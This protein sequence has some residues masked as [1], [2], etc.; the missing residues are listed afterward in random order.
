MLNE[1]YGGC[2][3]PHNESGFG[4]TPG[5]TKC[6]WLILGK[7]EQLSDNMTLGKKSGVILSHI[8]KVVRQAQ[9]SSRWGRRKVRQGSGDK[10]KQEVLWGKETRKGDGREKG[11]WGHGEH[12][13]PLVLRMLGKDHSRE[14]WGALRMRKAGT[15]PWFLDTYCVLRLAAGTFLS[16]LSDLY[17]SAKETFHR[18]GALRVTVI[19]SRSHSG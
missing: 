19:C 3:G 6:S 1:P 18:G 5:N 17:N 11:R 16:M 4:K 12:R 14:A 8:K 13:M 10:G 2:P 15:A 9:G 7:G